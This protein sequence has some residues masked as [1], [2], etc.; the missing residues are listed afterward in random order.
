M[1]YKLPRGTVHLASQNT[2]HRA[3]EAQACDSRLEPLAPPPEFQGKV[4]AEIYRSIFMSIPT[5]VT[6]IMVDLK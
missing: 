3:P 4:H 2:N 6:E 5:P 1:P